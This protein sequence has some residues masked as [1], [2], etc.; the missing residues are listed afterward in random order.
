M[1]LL[2]VDLTAA[3]DHI[4]RKWLFYSIKLR[5]TDIKQPQLI[6]ILE[7]LYK[8]TTLTFS[9]DDTIFQTTSGV[10]QGGPESP[11]FFNLYIDFVMRV[12]I[13]EC[14]TESIKFFEHFY[15]INPRSIHR[16]ERLQMRL[17]N[18][19]SWGP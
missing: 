9:R 17:E 16:E 2:F 11:F 10:C 7:Q 8:Q 1:F 4:P 15:R 6:T 13:H 14:R 18:L 3:F 19:S 5:F 12:F